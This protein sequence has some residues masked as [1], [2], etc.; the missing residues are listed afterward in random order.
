MALSTD[1]ETDRARR[2]TGLWDSA[3]AV[4]EA[5]VENDCSPQAARFWDRATADVAAGKEWPL[6]EIN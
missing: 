6:I 5:V 2:A 3:A 1:R 4:V